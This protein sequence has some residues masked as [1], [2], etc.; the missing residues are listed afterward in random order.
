MN[1]PLLYLG[2]EF[3]NR[4]YVKREDLY[5]FSLGGN[6]ARISREYFR[7]I[8]AGGYGCV[9][10][11]GGTGSNLC[12]AVANLAAARG[13]RCVLILYTGRSEDSFNR[14]LAALGGAE[15]VLCPP[16]RL[17]ET[18]GA[19]LDALRS[20]GERPYFIPGGGRG[21]PGTRA[22]AECYRE[23]TAD[24]QSAAVSFD[25][26]FLPSGTGTT[27]AGL[28]CGSLL[29]GDGCRIVGVSIA[30][31]AEAGRPVILENVREYFACEKLPL[32]DRDWEEAVIFEDAYTGGGY[33]RGDYSAT[34]RRIWNRYGMSLDNTYTGKAFFGM[35]EYLRS[36]SVKGKDILFV[37]TGGVPL[38]FDDL[39]LREKDK[40]GERR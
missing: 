10:T 12:R 25:E 26:I 28:V 5:P 3:D 21:V 27:Q 24:A 1:T 7:E 23:I 19:R 30:R 8:D 20:A 17:S 2:E 11:C 32:P 4:I 37:N 13:L 29:A 9:V 39:L 33:G 16:E 15:T 6:K 34:V 22:Y 40:K 38:L 35:G 36:H 18:I 14:K 31:R